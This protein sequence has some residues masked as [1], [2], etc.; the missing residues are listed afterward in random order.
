MSVA[1]STSQAADAAILAHRPSGS[2]GLTMPA[3]SVSATLLAGWG[4]V[5][6]AWPTSQKERH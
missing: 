4:S 5:S 2:H 3:I 1:R 6:M